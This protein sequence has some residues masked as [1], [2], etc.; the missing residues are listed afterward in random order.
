MRGDITAE[1]FSH[2]LQR[3]GNLKF[4]HRH[5]FWHLVYFTKGGG[6]HSIDFE[7][8]NVVPGQIYFMAPGQVHTWNFEGKIDGYIINF[9][10][11]LMHSFFREGLYMEQFPFFRGFA[12]ECVIQLG[13]AGK[14]IERL[15]AQIVHEAESGAAMSTEMICISLLSLFIRV[16]RELPTGVQKHVERHDQLL[17]YQFRKLVEQHYVQKHLP[18]EYAA[19]LHITPNHLNA[20][21]RG[22]LGIQAG[23]VIR[24]RILLEAKRLL[25]GH[26]ISVA[27]IAWQL[28]FSDNSYFTKFFKKYTGV[29]PEHFRALAGEQ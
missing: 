2:Y 14:D 24:D 7:T 21:C 25:A 12:T 3:H 23:A 19:M 27:E 10:G 29:T 13:D 11:Q 28:N 6:T 26:D 22:V 17:V 1:R 8:Y 4:P 15:L 9:P 18:K 5:S 20:V 16:M